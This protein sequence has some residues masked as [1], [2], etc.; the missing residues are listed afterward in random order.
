MMN[1]SYA[2]LSN[3]WLMYCT[4]N[5]PQQ[6]PCKP[7][8]PSNMETD[9]LHSSDIN[10]VFLHCLLPY[11]CHFPGFPSPF[12]ILFHAPSPIQGFTWWG[13]NWAKCKCCDQGL[14]KWFI[15][16]WLF[17]CV[18]S[19]LFLKA[20]C[21]QTCG[22]IV[23]SKCT[24]PK[25]ILTLH[26]SRPWKWKSVCIRLGCLVF[27]SASFTCSWKLDPVNHQ[28]CEGIKIYLTWI[29]MWF[30]ILVCN[31]KHCLVIC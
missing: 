9:L 18:T 25:I 29:W 23:N 15:P 22:V 4:P 31:I 20:H 16:V 13:N 1:T 24:L 27:D 10:V 8:N 28:S 7:P 17:H 5:S 14:V 12:P 21:T 11:H 2:Y 3:A 19:Y 6:N 26:P 30:L